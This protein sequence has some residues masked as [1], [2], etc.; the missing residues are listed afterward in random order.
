MIK[1][2]LLALAGLAL[3]LPLQA[4]TITDQVQ[5]PGQLSSRGPRAAARAGTVS[6]LQELLAQHWAGSWTDNSRQIYSRYHAAT[7]PGTIRTDRKSGAGWAPDFAHRYQYTAAGAIKSD[8]TDQYEQAPYGAYTAVFAAFDTPSRRRYDWQTALTPAPDGTAAWDS[9]SRRT[10]TYNAT[11]Q[12]TQV[13]QEFYFQDKFEP[14]TRQLLTYNALGQGVVNEVQ[15]APAAGSSDWSPLQRATYIYNAAGRVQQA[16]TEIALGSSTYS[17]LS[18]STMQFDAQDRESVLTIEA[19][20]DTDWVRYAQ[21]LYA[22]SPG[23]DLV[24]ATLLRWDGSSYQNTERLL[25]TYAQV[26]GTRPAASLRQLT[27]APNPGPAGAPAQLLLAADASAATGGVYDQLGRQV[28][29]L[30]CSVA[31]A[32]RGSLPLPAHLPAGLYVVRLQAGARQWQ[33]RWDQR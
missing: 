14:K 10:Y 26:L 32:A 27:I 17:N 5:L 29:G 30:S 21:T 13:L 16:T 33:A 24:S 4:Q 22:Y 15:S 23:G 25:F 31:Q 3:T 8:T 12:L 11:G 9:V 19:W 7:L 6:Q 28:A 1:P 20:G 2:L 18:R